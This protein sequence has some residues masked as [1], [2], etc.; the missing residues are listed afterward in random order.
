MLA[1]GSRDKSILLRDVRLPDHYTD[2]LQGHRSEICGLKVGSMR[3]GGNEKAVG[4]QRRLACNN[5]AWSQ[6]LRPV[7]KSST[8]HAMSAR[9]RCV[10]VMSCTQGGRLPQAAQGPSTT[11]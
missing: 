1:S 11:S 3:E 9:S 2:K 7:Q 6:Q 10:T 8:C 5:T 4:R